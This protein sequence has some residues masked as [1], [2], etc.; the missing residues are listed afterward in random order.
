M[1]TPETKHNGHT[2]VVMDA[3]LKSKEFIVRDPAEQ[4]KS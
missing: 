3:V 4:G 1:A 2:A